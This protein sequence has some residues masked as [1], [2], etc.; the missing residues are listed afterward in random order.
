MCVG[1]CVCVCV[2]GW[3]CVCV[4]MYHAPG[5]LHPGWGQETVISSEFRKVLQI[6]QPLV[7][8]YGMKLSLKL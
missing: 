6:S 7:Q 4:Y 1:V 5:L 3:G 2:G 8:E